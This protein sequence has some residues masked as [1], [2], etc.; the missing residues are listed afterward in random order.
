MYQNLL[1]AVKSRMM[2]ECEQAFTFHPAYDKKVKVYHKFPYEERLQFGVLLRNTSASTLRLS[3]DNYMSDLT[4]HVRLARDANYPGLSIEWVREN[5]FGVTTYALNEDVSLQL[6]PT[7]RMFH[8]SRQIVSG[9]DNTKYADNPGQVLVTVDG[10][11]TLPD[12]VNG[13]K[14]VVMLRRAPASGAVVKVSYYWRS[15][16]DPGVYVIDFTADN[17]FTVSPIFIINAEVVVDN[18]AGTE[19]S[20][21]L[22]HGNVY[23]NL[24]TLYTKSRYGGSPFILIRNVDYTI[25]YT[26]GQVALSNPLMAGVQLLADY[27]WQPTGYYNGPYTFLPYQDVHNAIPG[28]VLAIGRRAKKDDRQVVVLSQFRETQAR[29]YGGHWEMSMEFAVIAKDPIQMSEMADHLVSYLWGIRKN[30]LE[31]EGITLNSVE[32]SGETE[33]D[34]VETTGDKYYETSINVSLQTEWQEFVPYLFAIK[35]IIPNIQNLE[36]QSDY[37]V[38]KEGNFSLI[39]VTPDT[40]R[41]IKYPAMGYEKLT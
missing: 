9:D 16:S 6:G 3:A 4:S 18:T 17:E 41:V 27:R 14:Q 15:L 7:Q 33:E 5:E 28:V 23:P 24:E 13:E 19:T 34:Q 30:A 21:S 38:D 32:P 31:V 40:R 37:Y 26:T 36:N 25:N 12:Y 11:P 22:A 1:Y 39:D 8:T 29:I 10:V 35:Q 20:V 2:Y